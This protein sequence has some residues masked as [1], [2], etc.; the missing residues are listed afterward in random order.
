MQ[1]MR[2][3]LLNMPEDETY[4]IHY[5]EHIGLAYLAAS[6]RKAGYE[7]LLL[8]GDAQNLSID[9][10]FTK[11][12]DFRPNV[13]GFTTTYS[14]IDKVISMAKKLKVSNPNIRVLL[15]GHHAHFL[16]EK[17][18]QID[19][20]D[21]VC[22]GE[23]EETLVELLNCLSSNQTLIGC[24]GMWIKEKDRII[25]NKARSMPDINNLP[26]PAR[27]VLEEQLK[28]HSFAIACISSSRGCIGK[29]SFCSTPMFNPRWR[30]RTVKSIIEEIELIIN[31]YN[32][33]YFNFNDDIF[34]IPTFESKERARD[35]A[36]EV[37]RRKLQINFKINLRA[38]SLTLAD[39]EIIV[40]LKKAGLI[41]VFIGLE[42]GTETTLEIYN[43]KVSV[44]QNYD[45]Y[46]LLTK[47]DLIDPTCGFILFN[48]YIV[49][50]E[51]KENLKFYYDLG[52]N[53]LGRLSQKLEI[54]PGSMMEHRL[55]KDGN[56]NILNPY[57]NGYKFVD[58][59]V[60][61]IYEEYMKIVAEPVVQKYLGF[62]SGINKYFKTKSKEIESNKLLVLE[63]YKQRF[64]LSFRVINKATYDYAIQVIDKVDK[65]KLS[66][67]CIQRE[68]FINKI[69]DVFRQLDQ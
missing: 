9:A 43:K 51:L 61:I 57:P 63:T 69:R 64:N 4:D 41:D 8:D 48:P 32:L 35:F 1:K 25:K 38:N 7:T 11:V 24:K 22:R 52:Q 29:C 55:I 12:K 53:L 59:K 46:K 36:T 50:S 21:F 18:L 40:L 34:I 49:I 39:E 17:L 62:V 3:A 27:D 2:L 13:V 60:G 56:I 66:T 33:S 37:L 10:I 19:V 31:N 54:F 26:F 42:S 45:I 16:A 47:H 44:K 67:L 58:K 68:I 65:N 5:S 14:I 23:G 20:I 28:K 6:A 15:G 30:S